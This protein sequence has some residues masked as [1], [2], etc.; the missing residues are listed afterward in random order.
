LI[1]VAIENS[2][3]SEGARIKVVQELHLGPVTITTV[4]RRE[5]TF[6]TSKRGTNGIE[7]SSAIITPKTVF[8]K[9]SFTPNEGQIQD[10]GDG[11]GQFTRRMLGVFPL[12][13]REVPAD[14]RPPFISISRRHAVR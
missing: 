5:R 11:R 8:F 9:N 10:A 14:S 6:H 3:Q 13:Y 1:I 2:N 4:V 12:T 7:G